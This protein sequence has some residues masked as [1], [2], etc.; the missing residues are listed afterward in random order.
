MTASPYGS[1]P[2]AVHRRSWHHGQ[3]VAELGQKCMPSGVYEPAILTR[4]SGTQTEK[5]PQR[6]GEGTRSPLGAGGPLGAFQACVM[7]GPCSSC[8]S[9]G[10]R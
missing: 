4:R 7:R 10:A 5:G 1:P 8:I 2:S 3:K 9:P 6:V